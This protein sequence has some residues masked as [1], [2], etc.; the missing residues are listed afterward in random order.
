MG[1]IVGTV[2]GGLLG[3]KSKAPKVPAAPAA[4]PLSQFKSQLEDPILNEYAKQ[5][6]SDLGLNLNYNA[7]GQMSTPGSWDVVQGANPTAAG[8]GRRWNTPHYYSAGQ[9]YTDPYGTKWQLGS[10][11]KTWSRWNPN[12]QTTTGE[13]AWEVSQGSEPTAYGRIRENYGNELGAQ[14]AK[15]MSNMASRGILRSGATADAARQ[16]STATGA[17]IANAIEAQRQS[18]L[19]RLNALLGGERSQQLAG[20]QMANAGQNTQ[21]TNNMQAYNSQ[22][23]ARSQ[24]VGELANILGGI[25]GLFGGGKKDTTT[26]Y[27]GGGV[28]LNGDGMAG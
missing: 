9:T 12:G 6:F 25:G 1:S 28:D 14:Q 7:A 21:F 4:V 8:D 11:R 18:A 19:D 20:A 23:A 15:L 13:G 16:M 3:S 27:P 5:A 22:N 24:G 17:A 10:D 2:V 26:N